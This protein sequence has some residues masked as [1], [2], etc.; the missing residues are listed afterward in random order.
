MLFICLLSSIVFLFVA[1][2]MAIK[3]YYTP[4]KNTAVK[5]GF[6]GVTTILT[7][8]IVPFVLALRKRDTT[9]IMIF[10]ISLFVSMI[11]LVSWL[12]DNME[13]FYKFLQSYQA[14]G[15]V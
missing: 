14:Q 4:S 11:S 7:W 15:L 5:N 1:P 8:P 12:Q 2:I 13:I 6:W 10:C 9:I 3:K